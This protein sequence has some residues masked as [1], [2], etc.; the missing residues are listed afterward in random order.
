MSHIEI[1]NAIF[2]YFDPSYNGIFVEVGAADPVDI[3]ISFLFRSLSE[4][5]RLWSYRQAHEWVGKEPVGTWDIISIEA[6]PDFC[7][8]FKKYN[9]PVLEYAACSDDI[10]ETTFQISP[11]PMS[12]SA[13]KV[14]YGGPNI[15]EDGAGGWW[16]A[17][18]FKEITVKALKL[19]TILKLHRPEINNIDVLVIDTEGWELEVLKGFDLIKFCPKVV[20]LENTESNPDYGAYMAENKYKLERHE[21]QDYFYVKDT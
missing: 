7:Q 11:C 15:I 19:D 10:G 3:S 8:E 18:E 5:K 16:P 13:L 20:V 21:H 14:R 1:A 4:Q 6:N 17:N 12:C 9:L 2:G